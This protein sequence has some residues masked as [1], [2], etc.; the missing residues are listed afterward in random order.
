MQ[1]E[2]LANRGERV[3]TGEEERYVFSQQAGADGCH[4]FRDL[5]HWLIL[6]ENYNGSNLVERTSLGLENV[7]I[8]TFFNDCHNL[9]YARG[10][11]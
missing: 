6:R 8:C 7:R 11:T 5:F 9:Q 10:Q 4:R 2:A 3:V 1:E